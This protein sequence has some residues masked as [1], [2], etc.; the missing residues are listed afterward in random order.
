MLPQG[1]DNR[2]WLTTSEAADPFPLPRVHGWNL[3]IRPIPIREKTH[4]GLILPENARD[5]IKY[6]TN[7]GRVLAVGPLAYNDKE[8][9]GF[10]PWVKV[11]DIVTFP[12]FSGQRFVYKGVKLV[13][14]EDTNVLFTIEN[15]EDVDPMFNL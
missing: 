12:R 9:F 10:A 8:K 4:S 1:K 15:A 5:D 6:L 11:G 14:I 2:D 7:V 3:V 13:L